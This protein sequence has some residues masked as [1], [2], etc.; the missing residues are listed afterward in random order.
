MKSIAKFHSHS[1]G[2]LLVVLAVV[3]VAA[4]ITAGWISVMTAQLQ[5]A[6]QY[7]TSSKRRVALANATAMTRQYF[8]TQVLTK[9]SGPGAS[10]DLGDG[11]GAIVISATNDTPLT[12][13][14]KAAGYNH[15]SP[16][17]G[18]GYSQSVAC[19]IST[20]STSQSITVLVN[21]RSPVLS[22]IP[23]V[24]NSP[25]G[26]LSGTVLNEGAS[27]LCQ[28]TGSF[29]VQS[30]SFFLPAAPSNAL[31]SSSGTAIAASNFPF[32]PITGSESGGAASYDGTLNVIQNASGINSLSTIVAMSSPNGLNVIDGS[33]SFN[34]NGVVCD[35]T[36][37]VTI[38]LANPAL[39][40]VRI[41]GNVTNLIFTGQTTAA[42]RIIAGNAAAVLVVVN[43]LLP[44]ALNNIE[45]GQSNNRKLALAI[46]STSGAAAVFRFPQSGVG[47]WRLLLTL[48]AVPA[49][50]QLTGG[51]QILVGGIQSDSA[52][53]VTGGSLTVAEEPDPKLMERLA[54]R[55]G[56]LEVSAQ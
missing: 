37:V 2:V 28:A 9:S 34:G 1:G 6:E 41:T 39:G 36:G 38:D 5:Y 48:E 49:T 51:S 21:S 19:A 11:W 54:A 47:T 12:T 15:F 10:I 17:N 43:Q 45:F 8:L 29:S 44:P 13:F 33:V 26:S 42:D 25:A 30:G 18:D 27:L 23:V 56:W 22:G 31:D 20:G 16:G 55:D 3:L 24:V 4:A 35:G 32:V 7:F 50:I 46:K 52:I 14:Q 53:A 40:N